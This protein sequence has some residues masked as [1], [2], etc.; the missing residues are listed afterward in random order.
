MEQ[1]A[2]HGQVSPEA[3]AHALVAEFGSRNYR[4]HQLGEPDHLVV[5]IGRPEMPASGGQTSITVHLIEIDDGVMVR[6]GQQ[7]W[8]G[9]AASLGVTALSAL[10]NPFTLL[11]RLDDLAQDLDAIQLK[12]RIWTTLES[13]ADAL[14]ASME[15][16]EALRR[17][18]CEYCLTANPVGAPSCHACGAPLGEAQ[19]VACRSCGFISPAETSICPECGSDLHD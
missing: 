19:P 18:T 6:L 7:A 3:F 14:G 5:Q 8:L 15:M 13:A 9:V 4:V 16:A 1:R 10:R 17:I 2:Y 11:G 12:E